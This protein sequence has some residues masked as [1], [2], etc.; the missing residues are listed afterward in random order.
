[1]AT[2]LV[3]TLPATVARVRG[4][5]ASSSVAL[6]VRRKITCHYGLAS[7]GLFAP[8]KSLAGTLVDNPEP[9]IEKQPGGVTVQH[10]IRKARGQNNR[11]R[12]RPMISVVISVVPP[13]PTAHG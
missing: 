1:M 9:A 13:K 7:R 2:L 4:K 10:R 3:M 6:L 11:P 12:L 5:R 8:V